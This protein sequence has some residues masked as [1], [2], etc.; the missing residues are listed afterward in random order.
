MQLIDSDKGRRG[1]D[2]L[3]E[4]CEAVGRLA[5]GRRSA[6]ARLEAYLGDQLTHFLVFALAA[7]QRRRPRC[8]PR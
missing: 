7:D 1:E 8:L 3:L 2:L 5:E 4:H 6:A